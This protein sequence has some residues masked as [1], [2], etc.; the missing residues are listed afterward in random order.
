MNIFFFV[1]VNLLRG[2]EILDEI[3]F[4]SFS[5]LNTEDN[6]GLI[7]EIYEIILELLHLLATIYKSYEL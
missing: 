5:K 6:P 1:D 2:Y 3:D 4:A 7:L